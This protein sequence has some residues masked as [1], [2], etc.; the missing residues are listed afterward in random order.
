[1]QQNQ[2]ICVTLEEAEKWGSLHLTRIVGVFC[3]PHQGS[4]ILYYNIVT[5]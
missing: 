4:S 2:D 5:K 3:V 1:M